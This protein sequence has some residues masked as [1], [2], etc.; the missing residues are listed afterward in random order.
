MICS[1]KSI[2]ISALNASNRW[3]HFLSYLLLGF[4]R[5]NAQLGRCTPTGRYPLSAPNR[6]K[7]KT[8][9]EDKRK[10]L[11]L[12]NVRHQNRPKTRDAGSTRAADAGINNSRGAGLQKLVSQC[13]R[14]GIAG[15]RE[16]ICVLCR[17]SNVVEFSAEIRAIIDILGDFFFVP[18]RFLQPELLVLSHFRL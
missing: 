1:P 15:C 6:G 7:S 12:L 4:R 14:S 18:V 10:P 3:G 2:C 8:I 13:L 16:T 9:S 11:T 5:L 17:S